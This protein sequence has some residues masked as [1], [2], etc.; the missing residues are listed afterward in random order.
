MIKKLTAVRV[1]RTFLGVIALLPALALASPQFT[2]GVWW[3]YQYTQTSDFT[4]PSYNARLDRITGGNFADPAFILYAHD[5]GSHGPWHYRAEMRIGTGSFTD[6]ANNNSHNNFT[7]HQAWIGYD[8]NDH[9]SLKIGKSQVPFGWKT[10]NFWPGDG[11]Q[12]GYG[13][14]MDVGLKLSSDVGDIHYDLA[15]YH[16]DDWGETSTDTVDDNGHW[17]SSSTYRKIKTGVANL[18]W[19]FAKGNTIGISGQYGRLQDLSPASPSQWK[20]KGHHGALDLHYIFKAGNFYAKYRFIDTRRDFNGITFTNA[21]SQ[22]PASPIVKTRRHTAELGYKKN[23]W[24]YYIDGGT[25]TSQTTGNNAGR[26]QSYAPG[27]RYHYGPGW[28]YFEYLW[29][30]GDISR[31]GDVYQADFRTLYV[32]FDFYF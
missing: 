25:A 21:S 13:D 26:V 14:Q 8:I 15:Y 1:L 18:D 23:N 3:V 17:G 30:N 27:V 24:F 29:Q 12:G 4:S 31:N 6:P 16:Q 10:V 7:M 28:I 22:A 11:L 9:T 2:A 32:A 5:D 19:T 20:D